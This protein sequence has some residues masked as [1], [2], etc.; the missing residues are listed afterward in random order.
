MK[1]A[2]MICHDGQ[3]LWSEVQMAANFFDRLQGLLGKAELSSQQGLLLTACGSV[4]TVGM[5]FPIDVIF[6]DADLRVLACHSGVSAWRMKSC[7][8]ACA[9]LEVAAVGVAR[10]RVV[11]GQCLRWQKA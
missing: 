2:G 9:T 7:R 6:L 8:G 11:P 4:H 3:V 10:H 1:P 5:R